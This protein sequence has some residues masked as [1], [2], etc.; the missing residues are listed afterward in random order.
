M[1]NDTSDLDPRNNQP[2][3]PNIL[4]RETHPA[5]KTIIHQG[6]EGIRAYYIESGR[7]EVVYHDGQKEQ[8]ICELVPG[9][10]FGEMALINN[11][12]RS[13]SVITKEMVVLSVISGAEIEKSINSIPDKAMRTLIH[14]LVDLLKQTTQRQFNG[15]PTGTD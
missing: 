14:V 4:S 8:R 11:E 9:N 12:P 15:E 13:A 6:D 2:N 1:T 10:I 7:V 5:G 3:P